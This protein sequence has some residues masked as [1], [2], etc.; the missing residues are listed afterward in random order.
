MK[1]IKNEFVLW[2]ET[3]F[4]F[5]PGAVGGKIRAMYF[6]G[7]FKNNSRLSIGL[8]TEF[9]SR[10][11]ISL[12][13]RIYIGRNSFFSAEYGEI[14]INDNTR[15]NTNVHINASDGGKISIGKDCLIGPNVVMRT[16]NHKYDNLSIPL[17][18][19]G[20]EVGEINIEDNVW[21]GAN[22][23][24]LPNIHIGEG[25]I[26]GAGSVVTKNIPSMAIAAGVPAK[27]IKYRNVNDE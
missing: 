12:H 20:H 25:A 24:L 23:I 16:A 18:E 14:F 6:E 13:G 5:I 9:N 26:I 10:K 19:Q 8:G 3:I 1:K 17:L 11:N 15:F 7:R 22:V 4:M 27:I 2:I 21:I